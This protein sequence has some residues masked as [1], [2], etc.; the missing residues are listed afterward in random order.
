MTQRKRV[1]LSLL[2]LARIMREANAKGQH[3]LYMTAHCLEAGQVRLL[4]RY[5]V[6]VQCHE[7]PEFDICISWRQNNPLLFADKRGF[8]S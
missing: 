4:R 7:S 1:P 3:K 5:E 8:I 6:T 2:K